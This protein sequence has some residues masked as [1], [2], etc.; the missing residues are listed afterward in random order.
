MKNN[1]FRT[2]HNSLEIRGTIIHGTLM[3]SEQQKKTVNSFY[4]FYILE[5]M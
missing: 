5:P 3:E 1:H 4:G 2:V